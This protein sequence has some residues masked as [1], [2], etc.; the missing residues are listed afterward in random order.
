MPL[1]RQHSCTLGVDYERKLIFCAPEQGSNAV[2]LTTAAL[3]AWHKHKLST[4]EGIRHWIFIEPAGWTRNEPVLKL[5]DGYRI[6]FVNCHKIYLYG[7]IVSDRRGEAI[8]AF[9]STSTKKIFG[10]PFLYRKSL[11]VSYS[12][13]DKIVVR[14]IADRLES[15]LDIFFAEK[16]ILAGDSVTESLDKGL[17]ACDALL[18][19][20]SRHSINSDWVRREYSFALHAKK[21]VI[22]LRLD[23]TVLPPMMRDIKYLDFEPDQTACI[24][25]I[26]IATEV[27]S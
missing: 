27:T 14:Q 25:A 17:E 9:D 18:L 21:K 24:E 19:C 26:F 22:P 23:E 13:K 15:Q 7:I 10:S 20:L 1:L 6:C 2:V 11:F 5:L 3:Y 8:F 4:E 16:S 12:T